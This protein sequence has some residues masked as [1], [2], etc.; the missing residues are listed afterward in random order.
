MLRLP[1]TSRSYVHHE[2]K[3]DFIEV[4]V[5]A[6]SLSI[7]SRADLIR[8]FHRQPIFKAIGDLSIA[9][10][11]PSKEA[12]TKTVC[13]VSKALGERLSRCTCPKMWSLGRR[14]ITA[15][16]RTGSP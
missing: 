13:S 9:P 1:T 11:G 10:S 15:S 8:G 16:S 14:R 2:P 5:H 4:D 3:V 6:R 7:R 12:F